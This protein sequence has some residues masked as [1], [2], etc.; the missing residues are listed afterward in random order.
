MNRDV[1]LRLEPMGRG[2]TAPVGSPLQDVLLEHGVEFP[3]GGHGTC[4]TCRVRV[5]EGRC[6]PSEEDLQYLG[7]EAVDLGW[8]LGCR[9]V[10]SQNAT[11][12]IAQW[13]IDVLLDDTSIEVSPQDGLGVAIDLGTT[14][15]A[16]QLVDLSDGHVL[17]VASGLNPQVPFGNDVMTRVHFAVSNPSDSGLTDVV[18]QFL[19][20]KI[21][22]L[23][24]LAEAQGQAKPIRE[25]VLVGNTVMHHLF[26]GFDVNP[27][28]RYPFDATSLEEAVFTPAELDWRL[29]GSSQVRFLPCLGGF[30]GSDILAGIIATDLDNTT[31]LKALVDLGT[32]GE[33]VIVDSQRI[34]CAA[35]AAGPA[36]EG[37]RI[38]LGMRASRGAIDRV[39]ISQREVGRKLNCHVIGNETPIGI[40]GSGLIDATACA[41]ELGEL[42]PNGRIAN[43]S[44]R[45]PLAEPV[46]LHQCDFRE[47][48]L[49]KGAIAAGTEILLQNLEKD[50]G[51]LSELYLCGAFGNHICVP[52]ARRVGLFPNSQVNVTPRGNTALLGTKM[53]LLA[54]DATSRRIDAVFSRVERFELIEDRQFMDVYVRNMPFPP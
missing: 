22:E 7:Q 30:V 8:R 32:N 45:L 35:T 50:T 15:V 52:N 17:A 37:A 28:A 18:R 19:E 41:L 16:M 20:D 21:V 9:G 11:L 33:I 14:T 53:A 13:D 3:C 31:D 48:Q 12:Q 40:C 27:L 26:C 23:L 34:L 43:G 38:R 25:I 51:D 44:D 24:Q 2:V 49:A 36:F 54:P 4:R 29:P 10:V 46:F 42:L 5:L 39:S 6:D 47:L 1:V